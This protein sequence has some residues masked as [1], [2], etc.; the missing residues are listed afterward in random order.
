MRGARRQTAPTAP[1]TRVCRADRERAGAA[2]LPRPPPTRVRT[3]RIL[4]SS[5]PSPSPPRAALSAHNDA[6]RREVSQPTDTTEIDLLKDDIAQAEAGIARMEGENRAL[7]AQLEGIRQAKSKLAESKARLAE[8]EQTDVPRQRHAI[9]LYANISN[10][11]WDYQDE[12]K[13]KGYMTSTAAGGEVRG[14]ELDPAQQSENFIVNY[15]WDK[16]AV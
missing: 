6:Q 11:R 1:L 2:H 5:A 16:M 4:G 13:V 10:I 14:F 3:A 15:L 9:S 12:S 7:G 8:I